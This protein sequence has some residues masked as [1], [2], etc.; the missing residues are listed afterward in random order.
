M[1]LNHV[2]ESRHAL[3]RGTDACHDQPCPREDLAHDADL[4]ALLRQVVLVY[5]QGVEEVVLRHIEDQDL[6]ECVCAIPADGSG[7]AIEQIFPVGSGGHQV[8][9][10]AM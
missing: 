1:R 5:A 4:Q 6:A 2:H 9:E 7:E 3:V 10:M 8:Y